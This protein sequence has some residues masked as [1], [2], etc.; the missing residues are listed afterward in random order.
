MVL[1]TYS[2]VKWYEDFRVT[3]TTFSIVLNERRIDITRQNTV[4]RRAVSDE[5]RLAM[6]PYYFASTAEYRTIAHLFGVSRSIL[7]VCIKEVCDSKN[8]R[9]SQVLYFPH[10]EEPARVMEC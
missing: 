9:L 2:E 6:T 8:R 3:K 7:C 10:G 5:R 4:M 1:A